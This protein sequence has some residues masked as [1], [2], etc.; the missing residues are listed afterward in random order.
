LRGQTPR[1]DQKC[2]KGD[3]LKTMEQDGK[4][5]MQHGPDK[6][7]PHPQSSCGAALW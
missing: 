4:G 3:G 6:S 7:L 5:R 2:V 1:I